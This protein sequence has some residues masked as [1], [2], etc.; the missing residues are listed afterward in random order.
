MQTP[1]KGYEVVVKQRIFAYYDD[2]FMA[3]IHVIV[4]GSARDAKKVMRRDGNKGDLDFNVGDDQIN[5]GFFWKTPAE[6]V[7]DKCP[8]FYLF[9]DG[10]RQGTLVHELW[11]TTYGVLH[12]RGLE[13]NEIVGELGAYYQGWL[14]GKISESLKKKSK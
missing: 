9:W 1:Q 2:L 13:D 6:Y 3:S 14:Y 7:S 11:H 12:D 4:G 5:E 8:G 10:D